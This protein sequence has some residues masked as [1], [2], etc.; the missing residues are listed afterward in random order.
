[1]SVCVECCV[2]SGKVSATG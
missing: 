2:L 1:M